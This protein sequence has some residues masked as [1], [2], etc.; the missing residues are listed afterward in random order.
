MID[1]ISVYLQRDTAFSLCLIS[2]RET[3]GWRKISFYILEKYR[4]RE[5][6]GEGASDT[7][8]LR[9]Q[10]WRPRGN[11]ATRVSPK[12]YARPHRLTMPPIRLLSRASPPRFLLFLPESY[13]TH[14][15][16]CVSAL[17]GI[18]STKI[19]PPPSTTFHHPSFLLNPP[20]PR[21]LSS[22]IFSR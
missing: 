22:P 2:S 16:T 5:E 10:G 9:E 8:I 18:C 20:F 11:F 3:S 12:I 1:T 21:D 17:F 6:G 19:P 14:P 13:H 15:I 7:H 4:E